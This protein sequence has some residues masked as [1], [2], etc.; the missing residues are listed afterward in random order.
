MKSY[1]ISKYPYSHGM[2][3]TQ[4]YFEVYVTDDDDPKGGR[5]IALFGD[6]E[7]AMA[8]KD[9]LENEEA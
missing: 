1:S 7:R 8:Y 3:R 2:F 9:M 5:A 4:E 6:H